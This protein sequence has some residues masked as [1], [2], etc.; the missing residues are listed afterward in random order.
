MVQVGA[1]TAASV[2]ASGIAQIAKIKNTNLNGGSG[3]IS[4]TGTAAPNVGVTPIEVTDDIQASP[5]ALAESQVAAKDQRVYIL[6]GDIQESNKR[7]EIRESN[8]TF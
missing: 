6:E 3:N 8:S 1:V 5:T 7:V 4:G 2:L